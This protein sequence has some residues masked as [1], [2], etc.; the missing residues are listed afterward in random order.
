MK[1]CCHRRDGWNGISRINFCLDLRRRCNNG[2]SADG[3]GMENARSS[4]PLGDGNVILFSTKSKHSTGSRVSRSRHPVC[5]EMS[6]AVCIHLGSV[7]SASRISLISLSV[8]SG[9]LAALSRRSLR[10]TS[11]FASAWPRRTASPM[12]MASSFNSMMAVLRPAILP[13]FFLYCVRQLMYS[14]AL[15]Y[16]IARGEW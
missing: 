1:N 2:R 15:R 13:V 9:F 8:N 6:K 10:L 7:F 5:R 3:I 14:S 16:V 11:G 12:I 4:P